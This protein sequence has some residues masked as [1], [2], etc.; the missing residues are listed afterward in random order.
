MVIK[1]RG[2]H[3]YPCRTQKLSLLTPMVL[4]WKRR[5]RVGSR[6]TILIGW[7]TSPLVG[8]LDLTEIYDFVVGLVQPV[9]TNL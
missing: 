7:T 1:A 5:G 2:I 3:L 4:R 9:A 8:D 6:Q